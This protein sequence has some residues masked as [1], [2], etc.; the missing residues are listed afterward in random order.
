[1]YGKVI[2]S[3]ETRVLLVAAPTSGAGKTTLVLGLLSALRAEGKIVQPFKI[4]PDYIDTAYHSRV[5]GRASVNLDT[6]MTSAAFV[7]ETFRRHCHGADIAV[8]EGVMGLFDGV[9]GNNELGSSAHLAKLLQI[10]VV[11]VVD[12]Y[13]CSRSVGAIVLGYDC[14][15]PKI[16]IA[17]VIF[18]RVAGP[19][20]FRELS[21][22]VKERCST[23]VLGWLPNRPELGLPE[24]Q[25]GLVSVHEHGISP[26]YLKQLTSTVREHVRMDRLVELAK[27]IPLEAPPVSHAIK[28]EVRLG[29][30][31]DEAFCF[32]YEDNLELL[33]TAGAELVPF[34]PLKDSSLPANLDG[35]Y[36]GGGFPEEFVARLADN[37]SMLESVK[38]FPGPILAECG[39]L[40]YLCRNF[41]DIHG[42]YY[43][44][45]GRIKASIEMT[46]KLKA[47]GYYEVELTRDTLLGIAGTKLRGHMFHWSRWRMMPSQGWGIYQS[48]QE[49]F[50]YADDH[51]LASYFHFH[52]GSCLTAASHFIK[53]CKYF[54]V[55]FR[56]K[57]HDAEVCK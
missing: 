42:N 49:H 34:S 20:H 10:P 32:Y 18:N 29:I 41:V 3:K 51:I 39:G 43:T 16:H 24:R 11:L 37:K 54:S 19:D 9:G 57:S 7:R 22:A 25:L 56:K 44:L 4:G 14:Y 38:Q 5:A 17:G 15:D 45:V 26:E 40:I 2:M 46:K 53:Q 30:A 8:V 55:H 6:W 28:R 33:A 23:E 35:L 13:A 1:M 47:C 21:M 52:L 31:K 27:P 36:L 12:A 48:A 50:G